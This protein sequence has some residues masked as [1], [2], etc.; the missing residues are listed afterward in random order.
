MARCWSIYRA[1]ALELAQHPEYVSNDGFHPSGAGY[2]RI[3]Q[4]TLAALA[5]R[6]DVPA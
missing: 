2:G 3:A 5:G 6:L 4:L 1:Q